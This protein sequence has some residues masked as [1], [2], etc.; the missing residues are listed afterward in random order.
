MVQ[1]ID[2]NSIIRMESDGTKIDNT[3]IIRIGE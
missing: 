3:G 1:R 2:N